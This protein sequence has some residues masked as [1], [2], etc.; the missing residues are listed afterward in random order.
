[1]M[2]SPFDHTPDYW[3]CGAHGGLY[4]AVGPQDVDKWW[5]VR[6]LGVG[7]CDTRCVMFGSNMQKFAGFSPDVRVTEEDCLRRMLAGD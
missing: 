3:A 2:T 1:M 7:G 5:P 4:I 6:S